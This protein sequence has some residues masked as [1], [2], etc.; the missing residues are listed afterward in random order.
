MYGNRLK[1]GTVLMRSGLGISIIGHVVVLGAGLVFAG[2][3]PFDLVPVAAI[4][5]DIVSPN[6]IDIAAAPTPPEAPS[7][8]PPTPDNPYFLGTGPATLWPAQGGASPPPART[9]PSPA[10]SSPPTPKGTASNRNARQA[11]AKPPA[12]S[13]AAAAQTAPPQFALFDPPPASSAPAQPKTATFPDMFAL[14]LALPDGSLGG[15]FDAPAIDSAEIGQ[16]E[17]AAFRDRI[18]TCASLP[19][20]ISPTDK[21]RIVLRIS[22]A[23]DGTLASEPMLIEG[24]PS[25]KGLALKQSAVQALRSC[26]PYA[27]LPAEKYKEWKSLDLS[28]TPRDMAPG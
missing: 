25:A 21:I 15:A 13:P 7:P 3:R 6:D 9:S 20:T 23:P 18:K 4:A 12:P 27:M 2:A 5:V 22:F 14:P 26:Q 8:T 16:D 10:Q 24:S 28:F 1:T 19:D 17:T 11:G